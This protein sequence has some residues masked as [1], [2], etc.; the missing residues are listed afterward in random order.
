MTYI[1]NIAEHGFAPD[2][3]LSKPGI[4]RPVRSFPALSAWLQVG[5]ALATLSCLSFVMS[6]VAAG[7]F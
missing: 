6:I 2:T 5:L 3:A 7:A 4:S 1:S